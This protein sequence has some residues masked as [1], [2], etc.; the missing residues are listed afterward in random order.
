MLGNLLRS[1]MKRQIIL[2]SALLALTVTV[3]AGLAF[4]D[5]Q[6]STTKKG[7]KLHKSGADICSAVEIALDKTGKALEK[8][9]NKTGQALGIAAD[10][11]SQ[12]LTKAG[13][14]IQGWFDDKRNA[15]K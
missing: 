1:K 4:D 14:K 12:A 5:K 13:K 8:A 2:I 9:G 6:D 15:S 3:N 10:K 11:T 7:G